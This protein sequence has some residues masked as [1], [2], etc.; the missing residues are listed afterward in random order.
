M[1][2][3]CYPSFSFSQ[4]LSNGEVRRVIG[5]AQ[6]F[7]V[8][9]RYWESGNNHTYVFKVPRKRG[10]VEEAIQREVLDLG[11]APLSVG[12][13]TDYQWDVF[14]QEVLYWPSSV[15]REDKGKSGKK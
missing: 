3:A 4:Q 15:L 1:F 14:T 10:L 11:L 13:A 5:I 8:E 6:K 2:I 9:L 12:Y 7:D